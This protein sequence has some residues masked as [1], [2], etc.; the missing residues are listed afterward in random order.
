VPQA[1]RE[2]V[3]LGLPLEQVGLTALIM[4]GVLTAAPRASAACRWFGTQLECDLGTS[5]LVIGTQ[6]AGEPTYARPFP[7]RS[8]HGDRGFR[9]DHAASEH[10]LAIELQ[11]FGA[12]PTLCR[13]I[14][15]ET[16]CY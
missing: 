6:A 11:D 1:I 8:F 12:D 3:L 15:N 14:G 10:P 2:H 16:Y 13:K 4:V 5:R 7:I 9:D